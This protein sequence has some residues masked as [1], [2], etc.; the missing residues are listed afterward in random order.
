MAV[1]NLEYMFDYEWVPAL[2]GSTACDAVAAAHRDLLEVECRQLVLAAHWIDLHAPADEPDAEAGQGH[3]LPG[4]ERRVRVGADGTPEIGEFACAEFAALQDLHPLAGAALLRK[5]ANLRHRHPRLWARVRRAEVRGWKALEVARIVG[6][7]E[8]ALSREQ[9]RWVDEQTHEWIDTLPWGQFLDLVEARVIACDPEG[10]E[11]R[12]K[13]AEAAM[14]VATGRSNEHGVKSFV[15]RALA[16]DVIRMVAVCDRI[17]Q[18]LATRGDQNPIGVRRA[19]AFGMLANPAQALL[20]LA[21]AEECAG[22]GPGGQPDPGEPDPGEPPDL[23]Q[24]D[25]HPAQ[26]DADDAE[27]AAAQAPCPSC[28]SAA[29]LVKRLGPAAL[30]R[31]LPRATLHIHATEQALESGQG[32]ARVEGAGPI[33]VGQVRSFL[34]HSRV[35][36]VRVVQ[37]AEQRPVDG[38]EF[39]GSVREAALLTSPRDVFPWAT[40]TSRRRDLDHPDPYLPPDRGGPPGQTRLGNAAP[41]TRFHHRI[42]TH[43]GWRLRQPEPGTYLWRSPHGHYWLTSRTGTHRLTRTVGRTLWD[44]LQRPGRRAG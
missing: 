2:D 1:T 30:S 26:N 29:A 9:A 20:L 41:M 19:T 11:V 40:S 44:A 27:H 12:R 18:I 32:V 14:F 16:G 43:G 6:K 5:V 17:A 37:P 24:G 15:A 34:R 35:S 8:C 36:P 3:T 33:T 25:L 38:Y 42:K 23:A 4:V 21:E 31:V 28:G 13:E 10:A 39:P 7:E 22:D